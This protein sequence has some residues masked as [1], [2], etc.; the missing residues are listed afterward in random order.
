[1]STLKLAPGVHWTGIL[2]PDLRVFDV[3][4]KADHGTTYN[5]YL[6]K[7]EKGCAVIET[8]KEK[9]RAQFF[10]NIFSLVDPLEITHIILNHT[11]MDHTGSL[12]ALLEEAPSATVVSSKNAVPFIKAILNRD[13]EINPVGDGDSIDLGGLTLEFIQAPFLHWPDTM[14]TFVRE[15]GILFPCDFFGSHF[16]DE[17]M[18]DNEV[19]DFSHARRYYFDHIIRP[20]KEHAIKA[21]DKIGDLPIQMIAPSHGPILRTDL[22]KYIGEY[23]QWSTSP[24][25]REKPYVLVFYLTSYGNT[26]LM[27][28]NV[29]LGAREAGAEVGVFDLQATDIPSILDD[30]ESAD[31]LAIGSLTINGDAVKPAWDLL[32][33]LATLKLRGKAAVAFGSYGWSG[34]AVRFME[35][36]LKGIKFKV[37]AEG[38]RAQLIPTDDDLGACREL[39]K[40][41]VESIST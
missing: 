1:L 39:G 25:K 24:G 16:A 5:S 21:M 2:D 11:E 8:A 14:F 28:E 6:V 37:P 30:L 36:R 18:Y 32:S 40:N 12:A 4:M 34:E 17:K 13:I 7:G 3:I 15:Q 38:V 20:F 9:Y 26:R 29:A 10:E 22:H 41:L 31:A 35:E 23:R 27:A 19:D 33:S